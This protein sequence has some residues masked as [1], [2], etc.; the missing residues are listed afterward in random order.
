[1]DCCGKKKVRG[2]AEKRELVTRLHRI[3]GQVRGLAAMVERDAYCVD[4]LTQSAAAGVALDAFERELLSEHIRLALVKSDGADRLR[5]HDTARLH[6]FVNVCARCASDRV[7]EP[8]R[9]EYLDKIH[10]IYVERAE[11]LVYK[12]ESFLGREGRRV[13]QPCILGAI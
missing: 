5:T 13:E 3:E 7:R 4:I 10:E 1:M 2:E 9:C 6:I 8:F 12:T 11:S